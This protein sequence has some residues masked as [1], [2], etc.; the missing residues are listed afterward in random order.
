M[1]E[2]VPRKEVSLRSHSFATL[3][4]RGLDVL[5]APWETQTPNPLH[6]I[7]L[8]RS[9][10]IL[11]GMIGAFSV[12]GEILEFYCDRIVNEG[13]LATATEEYSVRQLV[14]TVGYEPVPALSAR[15]MLAI[16][17]GAP[18]GPVSI[19]VPKGTAVMSVPTPGTLHGM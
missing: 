5:T 15:T 7:N 14:G 13:Y 12:V 1:A 6:H 18:S 16:T 9:D 19:T 2:I 4:A 10:G 17:V 3:Y 8:E 11:Q